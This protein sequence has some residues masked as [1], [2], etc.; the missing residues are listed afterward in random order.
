MHTYSTLTSL[1]LT[2]A[3]RVM[4]I[5]GAASVT[6][7]MPWNQVLDSIMEINYIYRSF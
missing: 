5:A 7:Y 3:N 2:S 6:C 1:L 4:K